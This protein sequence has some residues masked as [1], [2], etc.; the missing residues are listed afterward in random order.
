MVGQVVG[1]YRLT[2]YSGWSSLRAGRYG[3]RNSLWCSYDREAEPAASSIKLLFATPMNQIPPGVSE[4]CLRPR[5]GRSA[6]SGSIA[7]SNNSSTL[8]GATLSN[9]GRTRIAQQVNLAVGKSRFLHGN[10]LNSDYEKR[11][12]VA[13]AD[14]RGDY[15]SIGMDL[16]KLAMRSG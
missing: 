5:L 2:G 9:I 15:P 10:L 16:T 7:L 14:F 1:P 8:R 13:S 3:E 11:P 4:S 12:L 6:R